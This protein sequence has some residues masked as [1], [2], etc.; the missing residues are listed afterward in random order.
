MLLLS[1]FFSSIV[2]VETILL[3][4]VGNISRDSGELNSDISRI[5]AS[6]RVNMDISES[7]SRFSRTYWL[8]TNS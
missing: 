5:L 3:M 4:F 6:F 2:S 8:I 7:R 1:F